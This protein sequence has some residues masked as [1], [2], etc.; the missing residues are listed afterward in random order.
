MF[1]DANKERY[2]LRGIVSTRDRES[3]TNFATFTDISKHISWLEKIRLKVITELSKAE[4]TS[5]GVCDI[6]YGPDKRIDLFDD[7]DK[8]LSISSGSKAP[9]FST[10]EIVCN[11]TYALANGETSQRSECFQKEKWNPPLQPC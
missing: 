1:R 10:I 7:S 8:W 5:V 3:N 4:T 2:Y 9:E 6:Q 11:P